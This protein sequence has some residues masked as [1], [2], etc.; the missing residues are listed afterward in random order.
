MKFAHSVYRDD[1]YR[2]TFELSL[3]QLIG[4]SPAALPPCR[5][6]RRD[7]PVKGGTATGLTVRTPDRHRDAHLV[8]HRRKWTRAPTAGYNW[9]SRLF[10]CRKVPAGASLREHLLCPPVR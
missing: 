3:R 2:I 1:R 7:Q 8:H 10:G 5:S 9:W 4:L 6:G